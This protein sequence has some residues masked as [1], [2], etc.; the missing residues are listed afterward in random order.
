M[1]HQTTIPREIMLAHDMY[2][3]SVCEMYSS[4][5]GDSNASLITAA[6][7]A[8][9]NCVEE[10]IPHTTSLRYTQNTD[11]FQVM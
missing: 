1:N 9:H 10:Y 3:T 4:G 6:S 7:S 8:S 11:L 5:C 2:L